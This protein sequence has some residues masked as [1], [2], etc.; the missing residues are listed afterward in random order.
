MGPPIFG[1]GDSGVSFFTSGRGGS[2]DSGLPKNHSNMN[3]FRSGLALKTGHS[4]KTSSMTFSVMRSSDPI[5]TK[6]S[7]RV[8]IHSRPRTQNCSSSL[9]AEFESSTW[10]FQIVVSVLFRALSFSS[11]MA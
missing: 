3:C 1:S 6:M 10:L 2:S 9:S 5:R 4:L 8:L 7:F 11:W